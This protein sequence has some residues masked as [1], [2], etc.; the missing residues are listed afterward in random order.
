LRHRSR[1]SLVFRSSLPL[2]LFL[3]VFPFTAVSAS[4]VRYS[5][6][7]QKPAHHHPWSAGGEE[8]E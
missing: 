5:F 7:V 4:C 2:F 6:P 8:K 3:L 1:S